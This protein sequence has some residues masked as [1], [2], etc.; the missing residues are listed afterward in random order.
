MKNITE[1]D[2][3]AMGFEKIQVTPEESG[4][5]EGYYYFCYELGNG[6]CL[7]TQA[8]KERD[9]IFYSV[10]FLNI[11]DLGKFWQSFDVRSLIEI[12]KRAERNNV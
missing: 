4:D 5:P 10:E 9:A 3:L 11:P 6:E 12:L 1:K 2:L 7:L 8:N